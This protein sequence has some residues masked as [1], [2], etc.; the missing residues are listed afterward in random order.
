MIIMQQQ[1]IASHIQNTVQN[2]IQQ[3]KRG[4]NSR[5]N[6]INCIYTKNV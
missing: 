5:Q 3:Y 2:E 6:V 1:L 4:E